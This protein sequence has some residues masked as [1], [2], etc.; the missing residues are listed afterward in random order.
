AR[1][2]L[3]SSR[4]RGRLVFMI[5]LKGHAGGTAVPTL[6][7]APDGRRLASVGHDHTVR[8]W[9]LACGEGR[10]VYRTRSRAVAFSP[11]GRWLVFGSYN[12]TLR[13]GTGGGEPAPLDGEPSVPR[14]LAFSPK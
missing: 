13:L 14:A 5:L 9:D 11:C 1:A 4:R 12:E 6:A 10:V 8:L 2:G 3:S 7:F